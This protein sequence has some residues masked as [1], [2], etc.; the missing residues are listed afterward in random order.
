ML[1]HHITFK[2]RKIITLSSTFILNE[3]AFLFA[4][5][6]LFLCSAYF[7]P[8]F[9]CLSV[10]LLLLLRFLFCFVLGA[11]WK[12]EQSSESTFFKLFFISS[13]LQPETPL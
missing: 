10:L 12:E 2:L 9:F 6:G 4:S 8:R 7:Y 1:F 13:V 5:G 3:V 11:F